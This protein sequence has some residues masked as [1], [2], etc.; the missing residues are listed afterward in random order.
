MHS[1]V[2]RLAEALLVELVALEQIAQRQRKDVENEHQQRLVLEGEK[3]AV[4]A[5]LLAL[6]GVV[7]HRAGAGAADVVALCRGAEDVL[8]ARVVGAPA[9]VH[10][11]EVGK[12]VFIEDAD[13]V[14]DAFA[15]EGRAA[16]GR[17]DALLLCVAAGPAAV[18]GLAGKAHP[19]DVIAGVVGKLP[20]E[21]CLLYTSPSPRD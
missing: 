7:P 5:A 8:V 18:A 21:V 14:E 19:C 6:E 10:V 9:E 15:V 12:K 1:L 13:L 11:L 20:V 4:A 3:D 2:P 17:E 16:A